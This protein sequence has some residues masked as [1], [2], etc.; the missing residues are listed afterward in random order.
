VLIGVRVGRSKENAL[1]GIKTA[2][3]L[4]NQMGEIRVCLFRKRK[5]E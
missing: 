1:E 4:P 5:K 2:R 3:L